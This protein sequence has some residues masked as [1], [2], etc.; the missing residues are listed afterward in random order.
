F[1]DGDAA[2]AAA[3]RALLTGIDHLLI[4]GAKVKVTN[5]P[6]GED[7]NSLLQAG[8]INAIRAT[9]DGDAEATLSPKGIVEKLA[10]LKGLDYELSRKAHARTLGIRT[11]SLDDMVNRARA[12]RRGEAEEP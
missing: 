12:R 2:D 5:T 11:S 7:A 1:R 6:T 3:S 9:V 4:G 8:G 10:G